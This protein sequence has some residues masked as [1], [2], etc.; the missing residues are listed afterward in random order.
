MAEECLFLPLAKELFLNRYVSPRFKLFCW[1]DDQWCRNVLNIA[2]RVIYPS[3]MVCMSVLGSGM[4]RMIEFMWVILSCRCE[5]TVRWFIYGH[6]WCL[7]VVWYVLVW[8]SYVCSLQRCI[9]LQ[10]LDVSEEDVQGWV[11]L[12][13]SWINIPGSADSFTDAVKEDVDWIWVAAEG[14]SFY[15]TEKLIPCYQVVT[16]NKKGT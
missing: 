5:V 11:Y 10:Y 13:L 4:E 8:E 9:W 12:D 6:M 7:S 3:G 1:I 15:L 2:L 16:K 14:K